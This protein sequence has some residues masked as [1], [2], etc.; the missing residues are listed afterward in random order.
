MNILERRTTGEGVPELSLPEWRKRLRV[1]SERDLWFLVTTCADRRTDHDRI[2]ELVRDK[3]DLLAIMLE[4]EKLYRRLA[5]EEEAIVKISPY[6]LFAILLRH[7]RRQLAHEPFVMER[8]GREKVPLF[9]THRLRQ[10]LEDEAT[11]DYL[12]EMLAS[13]VKTESGMVHFRRRGVWYRYR[14]S[15]LDLDS[16]ATLAAWVEEEF[17]FPLYK[18]SADVALFIPGVFPEHAPSRE[19]T[20]SR[21]QARYLEDYEEAGRYFYALAARHPVAL[22]TGYAE[23]MEVIGEQFA[24]VRRLLNFIT[25]RYLGARRFRWFPA[26]G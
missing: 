3:P 14:F 1:L 7:A 25:D 4:D 22:S 11:M 18:R 20:V 8:S 2:V 15:D 13:F 23:V 12:V 24:D 10:L 26:P 6:L 9:V 16:L 21:R 17:R 19:G 5:Q